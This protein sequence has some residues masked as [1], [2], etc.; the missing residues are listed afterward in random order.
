MT[1]Q[2]HHSPNKDLGTHLAEMRST[3]E[4]VFRQHSPAL[5]D[6]LVGWLTEAIAFHDTGKG[7]GFFQQYI[8]DPESYDGDPMLKAHTPVS[9]YCWLG[10]AFE[11]SMEWRKVLAVAALVWRHHGEFPVYLGH[12]GLEMA[13]GRYAETLPLQ[14][15]SF[16]ADEVSAAVNRPLSSDEDWEK[17]DAELE[18]FVDEYEIEDLGLEGATLFRLQ[19]QILFSMLLE[20]DRAHLAL[21]GPSLDAYLAQTP[22]AVP[23][24]DAVAEHCATKAKTALSDHQ[25]ALRRQVVEAATA[26]I[27]TV[28]LPTGMGKT[29]IGAEWLLRNRSADSVVRKMIIVLPFLS[30]IDQTVKEY[31][32]LL[33]PEHADHIL[34][35][36]SLASREYVT[37]D[38]SDSNQDQIHAANQ[39]RDFQA[40]TWAA[41]L[42]VTTFDQFLLA[43]F[44]SRNSH[45]LRCSGLADAL[46]VMDEIQAVP[47][48]LWTCMRL[49]FSQLSENFNTRFLVM[50]ATQPG[51][52]PDA[53]EAVPAPEDVFAER[54][55]YAL[56]LRHRSPIGM[57][58]FEEECV[59]R[60][61]HEWCDRRVLI[62]VNTRAAARQ[63]R[64]TMT[65]VVP[66]DLPLFFLSADV[67][68][69]ERL[70]YI[71]EI[72]LGNPCL[73]VS[74]QCVEA[75]VDID[76]DLVIRDFA[77][78]DSIVQVAGRCN[79]RGARKRAAVEVLDLRSPSGD[80]YA[81]MVYDSNILTETRS[82][83]AGLDVLPEED[84]LAYMRRYF[85]RL[86][87]I[88][89]QGV[90]I[91]ENWALWRA[92]INVAAALG[93][94]RQKHEFVVASEAPV[95]ENGC[96]LRQALE[97]AM[98]EHDR[99]ERKRR[100][101]S[102]A[103]SVAEVSVSIWARQGLEP[104]DIADPLGCWWLLRDGYYQRGHGLLVERFPQRKGVL[105]L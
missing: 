59:D 12:D 92:P 15:A 46:V 96:G 71:E 33:G 8:G 79:R 55:R 3:A 98:E 7:T 32:D 82:L 89:D 78:L 51:F 25:S 20:S 45:M 65:N 102:L 57:D 39:A 11:Q 77:P 100:L 26:S 84:V 10:H 95:D 53:V 69:R 40:E 24:P 49:A 62:V 74:T 52:L 83:L 5:K 6:M 27:N 87:T 81:N 48:K 34:E 13:F 66:A 80:S 44:S 47:P 17:V 36:H 63:L 14:L 9:L 72:K 31:R 105:C 67:V 76:M 58:E 19:V 18:D 35:S 42:V 60:L 23:G 90:D 22:P 16:P 104:E 54:K 28:T 29:L 103:A 38:E 88:K 75:G 91:A 99:W 41:P 61:T 1:L 50:S 73:V 68:P 43:L 101:R 56:H 21:S 70:G 30:V 86:R 93:K 37:C 85:E 4:M 94:G 97:Q 2:S 64:D